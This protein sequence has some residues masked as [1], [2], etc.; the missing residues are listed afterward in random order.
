[1]TA[2]V[3]RMV[4]RVR[5]ETGNKDFVYGTY[6]LGTAHILD[7]LNDAQDR[8]QSLIFPIAPQMFAETEV[9]HLTPG[10][11]TYNLNAEV[12][13][14]EA[15]IMVLFSP[16]GSIDNYRPL[17]AVSMMEY[18]SEWD[19]NITGY[20]IGN[21]QIIIN[22]TPASTAGDIMVIYS[23]EL[24]DLACRI[25]SVASNLVGSIT[26]NAAPVPITESIFDEAGNFIGDFLSTVD[27]SGTILRTALPTTAYVPA[28][29]VF[30][31][32]VLAPALAV[33]SW[34]VM[35]KYASTHTQCPRNWDRYLVSYAVRMILSREESAMDFADEDPVL[36]AIE[37]DIIQAAQQLATRVQRP[38]LLN[39]Y[40]R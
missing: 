20:N 26:L 33:N 3:A 30:T 28:T 29:R 34:V 8:L 14:G 2:Y 9:I 38:P 25:G 39:G 23:K 22:P 27:D 17:P 7:K 6:G 18:T 21:G 12:F 5:R 40:F 10:S 16:D 24:P 15:E 37:Q 13:L 19:D 36:Q 11:N 32:T 4:D 1:M 35:G 31:A